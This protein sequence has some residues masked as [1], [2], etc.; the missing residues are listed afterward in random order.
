MGLSPLV[1]T[2]RVCLAAALVLIIGLALAA[3]RRG[4]VEPL[5]VTI[6]A[7]VAAQTAAA[8][9]PA[10]AELPDEDAF[11]ADAA[12]TAWHH[13]DKALWHPATGLAKATPHYDRLTP[14]DIGS[15][16]ASLYSAHKLQLIGDAEYQKRLGKTLRTLESIP[17]YRNAVFHKKYSAQNARMID[18]NNAV[19]RTGYGWSATDLGRILVW[20]Y[21]VAENDA[22]FRDRAVRIA[23][24]VRFEETTEN[25]Y[26]YGGLWG[27]RGKLW[28]FQ[29]GRIG[30]EQYAA[31]GYAW[32][33]ADVGNALDLMKNA[34]PVEVLG[35]TVLADRRGL[36]RLNSEPFILAGLEFG[37][38]PEMRELALNVL[39]A[40]EARYKQ[41]GQ[42][43]M[44]SEDALNVKPHYF[45]YY[46]VYCNGKSFVVD[47][48]EPG[49]SLDGP[50]WIS[51]K[52]AFGW[53]TLVG[54]DYTRA[55][56]QEIGKA[57]VNSAWSSGIFEKTHEPTRAF[58]INTTAVVLEAALYRKLGRPLLFA[59]KR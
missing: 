8:I 2:S 56:L 46:C 20:L 19:S 3:Y 51:T 49:K 58:D 57:K 59:N 36:D 35:V 16:L 27:T 38:S 9:N 12:L 43:T 15:V 25:G 22:R 33:N 23:K 55:V 30:Y 44:V 47:V 24:R 18:R 10:R 17:L 48:A 6:S 5:P 26:L 7:A 28:K 42:L 13:F 21:I 53:H 52:A 14:W 32:W 54:N 4:R 40:Q 37:W 50:R 1:R 41:T 11:F 31:Q 29:E 45:Y 39:A 34:K